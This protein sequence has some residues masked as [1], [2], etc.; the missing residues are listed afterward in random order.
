MVHARVVMCGR[1]RG[2]RHLRLLLLL[3]DFRLLR[4]VEWW[5]NLLPHEALSV[6]LLSL[7][8][9]FEESLAWRWAVIYISVAFLEGLIAYLL[10]ALHR[11]RLTHLAVVVV[12]V[13]QP[14]LASAL[15]QRQHFL[16]VC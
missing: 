15:D 4:V 2:G 11:V 9:L 8:A 14:H 7:I 16:L 10:A 3:V 5:E 6:T 1:V 12:G 13:Q